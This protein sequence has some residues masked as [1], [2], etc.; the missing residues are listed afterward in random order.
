VRRLHA[1][2][3]GTEQR[4]GKLPRHHLDFRAQGGYVLAPPS[5]IGGRPYRLVR[6]QARAGQLAWGNAVA[7][8]EPQRQAGA[9]P[10]RTQHG[11]LHHLAGWVAGLAPDSH[12]RND[13]LFWAACRAAEAGDDAVLADLA[14]AART[15]GLTD[16]EITAT[17]ASAQRT[18][19]PLTTHRNEWGVEHQAGRGTERRAGREIEHQAGREATS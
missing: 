12:N 5:Q 10:A 16:R 6:H 9:Q 18:A 7:L 8:L 19:A 1:Y 3:A 13:G 15:T 2:Y 4:S 11:Q 17:I 14:A